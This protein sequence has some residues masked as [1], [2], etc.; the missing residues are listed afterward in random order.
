MSHACIVGFRQDSRIGWVQF[1]LRG[2]ELTISPR[3]RGNS[4]ETTLSVESLDP[5]YKIKGE[6]GSSLW[7]IPLGLAFLCFL[8]SNRWMETSLC[9]SGGS[10]AR[11]SWQRWVLRPCARGG[12]LSVLD[13]R[14]REGDVLCGMACFR[15]PISARISHGGCMPFGTP[16]QLRPITYLFT[17]RG[18]L[19]WRGWAPLLRSASCC[20]EAV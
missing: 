10:S 5:D 15:D 16:C 3:T 7:K 12:D 4:N 1:L 2:H 14:Q 6:S 11:P 18:R 13:G 8:L 19:R 9:S 17:G 20:R